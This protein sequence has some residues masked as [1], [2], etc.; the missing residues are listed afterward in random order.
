[1]YMHMYM[2]VY[3]YVYMYM[4][5]YVYVYVYVYVR[6]YIYIYIF[7]Y[8]YIYT[9]TYIYNNNNNNNN[10]NNHI[11]G[12]RDPCAC[13]LLAGP[14]VRDLLLDLRPRERN[15]LLFYSERGILYY[16]T[17][18]EESFTIL[19]RERNPLLFA[20]YSFMIDIVESLAGYS[21]YTGIRIITLDTGIRIIQEFACLLQDIRII[22]LDSIV[23]Y[24][25]SYSVMQ[26]GT[27]LYNTVQQYNCNMLW[28]KLLCIC[29]FCD[30]ASLS[31]KFLTRLPGVCSGGGR[32]FPPET[33]NGLTRNP[34]RPEGALCYITLYDIIIVQSGIITIV[35]VCYT[36]LH[37]IVFDQNI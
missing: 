36:I 20:H 24:M 23:S 15:P 7:I 21:H 30:S 10:N 6:I 28:D 5:M 19:L 9:Y 2:Y 34:L 18:R 37:Y 16:S 13:R 14:H 22:T 12:V 8:I 27:K 26:S 29:C 4:Y 11:Q 25:I 1:M 17:P 31:F 32:G 33:L 3:V 35:F